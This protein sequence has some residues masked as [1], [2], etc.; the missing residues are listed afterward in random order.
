MKKRIAV[1]G[2]GIAGLGCAYVLQKAGFEVTVF[3]KNPRVGGR[4]SSRTKNGYVFDLGADHLCD[5][6]DRIKYYCN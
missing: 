6:Y 3:E 4:M 2:A 5:L 1:I